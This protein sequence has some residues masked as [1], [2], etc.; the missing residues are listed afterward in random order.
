MTDDI[1]KIFS[2]KTHTHTLARIAVVYVNLYAGWA[3]LFAHLKHVPARH[4]P[5]VCGNLVYYGEWTELNVALLLSLLYALSLGPFRLFSFSS[6]SVIVLDVARCLNGRQP[7]SH[8]VSE[9]FHRHT[10]S[11]CWIAVAQEKYGASI[12]VVVLHTL[13]QRANASVRVSYRLCVEWA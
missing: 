7:K 8:C 4:R 10:R 13:H 2:K 12:V 11:R 1:N 5:C 3:T 9:M 6:L